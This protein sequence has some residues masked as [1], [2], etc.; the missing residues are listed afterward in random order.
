MEITSEIEQ[1]V[2]NEIKFLEDYKS[3]QD[4]N[5]KAECLG[6]LC[7][8]VENIIHAIKLMEINFIVDEISD[9]RNIDW[10]SSQYNIILE[11]LR[12]LENI[13]IKLKGSFYER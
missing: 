6:T 2:K 9:M 5:Y 7:C 13:I 4:A 12:S 1:L 10:Y 8:Q 3:R 11:E